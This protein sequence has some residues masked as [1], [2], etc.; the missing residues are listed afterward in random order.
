MYET[1]NRFLEG[2]AAG[3][4]SALI[5]TAVALYLL[6]GYGMLIIDLPGVT[7]LHKTIRLV[8]ENLG[9]SLLPFLVDLVCYFWL[10]GRLHLQL[11]RPGLAVET[12]AQTEHLLDITV[13]LF[14]GIGVIWTAVGMRGSLLYALGDPTTAA[15]EG[16]FAILQ[17]MVDGGI[18]LALSTTI[19]GGIGGYLMRVVKSLTVSGRLRQRYGAAAR[20]EAEEMLELLR[21]IETHLASQVPAGPPSAPCDPPSS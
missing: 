20:S 13:Q 1:W 19:L 21:R 6:H 12:I 10:L 14:F 11:K 5:I 16:A 2:L 17:R 4:A 15:Q 7:W 9:T 18:L 8:D 3:I